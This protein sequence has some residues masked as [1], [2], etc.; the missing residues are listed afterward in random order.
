M[1]NSPHPCWSCRGPIPEPTPFCPT[2]RVI[3]PPDPSQDFFGVFAIKPGFRIDYDQVETLYRTLQQQFHPDRFATKSP[4]ERRYSLEHVTRLNDGFRTLGDPL[5][6]AVYLLQRGGHAVAEGGG[7]NPTDPAFLLEVMELREGLAELDL[8]RGDAAEALDT[9]RGDVEER[10]KGEINELYGLFA[11]Y[12]DNDN[13][14]VLDSVARVVD[15]L[16]YHNRFLEELD[17]REESLY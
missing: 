14:T 12:F 5:A 10:C 8:S 9:M 1:I 6:L 13:Q 15:R 11:D 7:G 3:Q 16:R 4:K 2:C 17:Q